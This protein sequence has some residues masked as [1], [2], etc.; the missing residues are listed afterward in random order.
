MILKHRWATFYLDAYFDTLKGIEGQHITRKY[1]DRTCTH[2][3]KYTKLFLHN[4]MKLT[5]VSF[6]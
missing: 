6:L 2:L 4:Y 1:R 3:L 5:F